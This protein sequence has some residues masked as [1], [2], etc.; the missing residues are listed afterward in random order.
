LI[1]FLAFQRHE[2]PATRSLQER[3]DPAETAQRLSEAERIV[4]IWNWRTP[5]RIAS[6]VAAAPDGRLHRRESS[7][8][9]T[10]PANGGSDDL[11]PVGPTNTCVGSPECK[12]PGFSDSEIVILQISPTCSRCGHPRHAHII[13]E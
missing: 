9:E 8:G 4:D 2:R 5:L 10:Q 7:G 12:C 6:G 13:D 11:E 3:L 1:H